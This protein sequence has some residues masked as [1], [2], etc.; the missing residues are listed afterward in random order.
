M[1]IDLSMEWSLGDNSDCETCG[2]SYNQVVFQDWQDNGQYQLYMSVGCYGGESYTLDQLDKLFADIEG[3]EYYT[4]DMKNS[5]LFTVK[6][7]KEQYE[8]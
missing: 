1:T 5:I 3:F 4:D 6:K 2:Y 7:F 8:N